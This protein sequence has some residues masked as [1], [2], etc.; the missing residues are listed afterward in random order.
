MVDSEIRESL[1]RQIEIPRAAELKYLLHA[2]FGDDQDAMVEWMISRDS[3]DGYS[4]AA[5]ILSGHFDEPQGMFEEQFPEVR[6]SGVVALIEKINAELE[7]K[8]FPLEVSVMTLIYGEVHDQ[9]VRLTVNSYLLHT[10]EYML[11]VQVIASVT[12]PQH[13]YGCH[14]VLELKGRR[15]EISPLDETG[16]TSFELRQ[17]SLWYSLKLK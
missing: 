9:Q 6:G 16:H 14:V 12:L 1:L 3:R 17:P 15:P 2:K 8:Q 7:N 11:E 10:E 4:P 5:H 13:W